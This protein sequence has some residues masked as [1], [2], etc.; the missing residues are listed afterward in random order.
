MLKHSTPTSSVKASPACSGYSTPTEEKSV[1]QGQT[2]VNTLMGGP[3]RGGAT[4][5]LELAEIFVYFRETFL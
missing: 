3:A 1:R 4:A 2:H 5:L